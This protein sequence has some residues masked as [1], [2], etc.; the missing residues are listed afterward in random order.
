[1]TFTNN[2]NQN[3]RYV[4]RRRSFESQR[5]NVQIHHLR[6][7][8]RA[9]GCRRR[10][11]GSNMVLTAWTNRPTPPAYESSRL[12]DA[13]ARRPHTHAATIIGAGNN[14]RAPCKGCQHTVP[15]SLPITSTS[16]LITFTEQQH[17]PQP[18]RHQ[19]TRA[20]HLFQP[21]TST[22]GMHHDSPTTWRKNTFSCEH[23]QSARLGRQTLP[24]TGLDNTIFFPNDASSAGKRPTI[25]NK[26]AGIFF[27]K[28]P[29]RL[30]VAK[31]GRQ[32][33]TIIT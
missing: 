13:A 18:G 33:P 12:F 17:G 9:R 14:S 21:T 23:Q 4:G 26:T 30:L 28:H 3:H 11:R 32:R 2:F 27:S 31:H 20:G 8:S 1:L 10:R 19:Q 15:P 22:A 7:L 25:T 5:T 24:T 6:K 29:A 16:G